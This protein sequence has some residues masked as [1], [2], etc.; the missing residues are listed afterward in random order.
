[1]FNVK[2]TIGV[3]RVNLLRRRSPTKTVNHTDFKVT[4]ERPLLLSIET[5]RSGVHWDEA[6]LQMGLWHAAQ[7]D[8]LEWNVAQK[9]ARREMNRYRPDSH[10]EGEDTDEVLA[11]LPSVETEAHRALSELGFLPGIIVQGHRWH[12]VLSTFDVKSRVTTLFTDQQ[13]G[14]TQGKLEIYAMVAGLRR[15]LAW[16]LDVYLPW[17]VEHALPA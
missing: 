7:W 16:A 9:L 13:F 6:L 12:F 2:D 15:L 14:S 5:T 3:D 10:V 17:F 1:M 4:T 8:F 11:H